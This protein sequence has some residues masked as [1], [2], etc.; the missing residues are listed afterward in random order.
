MKKN[1][2]SLSLFGLFISRIAYAELDQSIALATDMVDRGDLA[3]AKL[4]YQQIIRSNVATECSRLIAQAGL[5]AVEET[6]SQG[7]TDAHDAK[8][9]FQEFITIE[10]KSLPENCPP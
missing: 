1:L 8:I 2:R 10:L 3:G 6:D 9:K 4:I 7:I 5:N